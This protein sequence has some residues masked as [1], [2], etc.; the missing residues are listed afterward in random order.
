MRIR[1]LALL[2]TLFAGLPS[3][4]AQSPYDRGPDNGSRVSIPGIEV[5]SYPNLPFTALDTITWTRSTDGAG[6][7]TRYITAKV[8]RDGEG[9]IYR[10]H[11][12]FGQPNGDPATTLYRFNILD[13]IA[14][15]RTTCDVHTHMCAITPYT[16]EPVPA[17]MPVG[18]FDSNRRYLSRE[19]LGDQTLDG[20]RVTGTHEAINIAPGTIGN[21][22]ELVL[23]REFWY[24]ADLKTNLAVTRKDPHDGI[25]AIRLTIQ[26]RSEP[27]PAIFAIPSGYSVKDLRNLPTVDPA[28]AAN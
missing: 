8:V 3:V 27:D 12:H 21:D 23:S 16:P 26:S 18:P 5:P 17:L 19:S 25:Q 9:R 6:T 20:L 22:R 15:T 13:P 28:V 7:T 11:H 1:I 4:P 14:Q 10:E 24:S 2:L